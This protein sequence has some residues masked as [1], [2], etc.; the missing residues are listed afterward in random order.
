[1][2]KACLNLF[3]FFILLMSSTVNASETLHFIPNQPVSYTYTSKNN[4]QIHGS[5]FKSDD[6]VVFD[7]TIIQ[8]GSEELSYP[9]LVEVNIKEIKINNSIKSMGDNKPF[10][11]DSSNPLK[12]TNPEIIS[13]F[14]D[15]RNQPLQFQMSSPK[16]IVELTGRLSAF[17]SALEV[18]DGGS[19]QD[20]LGSLEN[21]IKDFFY[22][23]SEDLHEGSKF[24]FNFDSSSLQKALIGIDKFKLSTDS[25]YKINDLNA[26]FIKA[27]LGGKV[28]LT[29]K[30]SGKLQLDLSGSI[31]WDANNAMV[32]TR[33]GKCTA[34]GSL[35]GFEIKGT[36]HMTLIPN[37]E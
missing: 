30:N 24:N 8:D 28:L 13:I 25:Y 32:Q 16:D 19:M 23:S 18:E 5:E 22:L 2:R 11:F 36:F 27:K 33:M 34:K 4:I 10:L 6:S 3:T 29:S 20:L 35:L 21:F 26:D 37:Q 17:N 31:K 12:A 14:E 15:L 9:F 1:M 7:I